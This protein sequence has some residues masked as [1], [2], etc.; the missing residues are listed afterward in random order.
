MQKHKLGAASHF[1]RTYLIKDQGLDRKALAI[2]YTFNN[3][4][5][6]LSRQ[7]TK[8]YDEDAVAA[9]WSDIKNTKCHLHRLDEIHHTL[10]YETCRWPVFM[11]TKSKPMSQNTSDPQNS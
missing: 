7:Y 10:G 9:L 6:P 2:K 8:Q 5:K 3:M 1:H 4:M 11:E